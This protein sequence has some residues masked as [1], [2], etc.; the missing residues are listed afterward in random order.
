MPG[1][2]QEAEEQVISSSSAQTPRKQERQSTE[3]R[4]DKGKEHEKGTT[5]KRLREDQSPRT[6]TSIKEFK[7]KYKKRA[8]MHMGLGK[9]SPQQT[10]INL[11]DIPDSSPARGQSLPTTPILESQPK[12]PHLPM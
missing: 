8:R 2:L 7:L 9:E 1:T 10:I 5:K 12:S 4:S 3:D 6:D 11:S